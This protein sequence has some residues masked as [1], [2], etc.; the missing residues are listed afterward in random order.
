LLGDPL[1]P[2]VT[3]IVAE[4]HA[5]SAANQSP[6]N[7]LCVLDF[8][9]MEHDATAKPSQ[10]IAPKQNCGL[11]RHISRFSADCLSNFEGPGFLEYTQSSLTFLNRAGAQP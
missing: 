5:F 4:S 11:D 10:P 6:N 9:M 1:Q 3:E 7:H 8:R 2:C